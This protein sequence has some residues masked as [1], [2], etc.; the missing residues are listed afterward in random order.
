MF[1]VWDQGMCG[2]G[3]WA[4]IFGQS[5]QQRLAAAKLLPVTGGSSLV[6][7]VQ[8]GHVKLTQYNPHHPT[9]SLWDQLLAQFRIG[10]AVQQ[11]VMNYHPRAFPDYPDFTVP[12]TPTF[13]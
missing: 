10:Q 2:L 7:A 3:E 12:G 11:P 1:N 13:P 5:A 8:G 9:M 6:K 4:T